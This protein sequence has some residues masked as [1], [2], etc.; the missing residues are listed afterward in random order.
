MMTKKLKAEEKSIKQPAMEVINADL[1]DAKDVLL[2]TKV[3]ATEKITLA[4]KM[5]DKFKSLDE[6][7]L[8]LTTEEKLFSFVLTLNL[9][10][11]AHANKVSKR[12]YL[13]KIKNFYYPE[14]NKLPLTPLQ[15]AKWCA[16]LAKVCDQV[17]SYLAANDYYKSA[18]NYLTLSLKTDNNNMAL[19]IMQMDFYTRLARVNFNKGIYFENKQPAPALAYDAYL[20]VVKI[21]KTIPVLSESKSIKKELYS[22]EAQALDKLIKQDFKLNPEKTIEWCIH[23]LRNNVKRLKIEGSSKKQILLLSRF[24]SSYETLT[25]LV[26]FSKNKENI[27]PMVFTHLKEISTWLQKGNI[28]ETDQLAQLVNNISAE[29][30]HNETTVGF[31]EKP[32]SVFVESQP[33]DK[34]TLSFKQPT[35]C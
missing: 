5:A 26:N 17:E 14:L 7:Y 28:K 10:L 4:I 8:T 12:L 25:T 18:I 22:I 21:V 13:E 11:N 30:F 27:K 1:A 31:W 29:M 16:E 15:K 32:T 2:I 6:N 35:T 23:A 20:E 24:R 19:K 34:E 3:K 33:V 9:M